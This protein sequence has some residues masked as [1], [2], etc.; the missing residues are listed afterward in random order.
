MNQALLWNSE[1]RG[2]FDLILT[3][4]LCTIICLLRLPFRS[5]YYCSLEPPKH[6]FI[7][8]Q[9]YFPTRCSY[10]SKKV[11]AFTFYSGKF[12]ASSCEDYLFSVTVA[13]GKKTQLPRNHLDHI[14]PA[15]ISQLLSH[16]SQEEFRISH[17]SIGFSLF[18]FSYFGQESN[19]N[20]SNRSQ[21]IIFPL[22]QSGTKI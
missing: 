17:R 5:Y 22:S 19:A 20:Y 13:A 15:C 14:Y 6:Q 2:H 18:T 12:Y 10:C 16:W 21:S 4:Q 8:T 9:F 3:G 7:L 1:N 11:C